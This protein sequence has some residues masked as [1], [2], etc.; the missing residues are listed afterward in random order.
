MFEIFAATTEDVGL[1]DIGVHAQRVEAMGYDGLFV[2][3]AVHDGLLLAARALA[4]TSRIR[5]AISVLVAFP[6]SPMNVALAAW[7]LQKMSRGRFEL[8]L[9]TQIRQNIEERYSARWLPPA[10]GMR[11]YVGALRAI[12]HSFRNPREPLH[13]VGEHYRFTRLQPFFNPG[14]IDAPDVPV[15]LGAVGPKMLALVGEV[16]DGMHTHPTNTSVRCLRET[17]LPTVAAGTL[18]R[19]PALAKPVICANGLVAT[20]IDAA[21]VAA[22]RERLR[23]TLAFVFSTPA[24]WR[25]LE[26]IG[27]RGVGERL[28]ALTRE[29]RWKEMPAALPDHVLDEFLVSGRYQDLPRV[30]ESRFGGLVDRIS[31]TVPANPEDDTAC[32]AAIAALRART[33]AHDDPKGARRQ[34]R[35][36]A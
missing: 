14:P 10:A 16:A 4:C 2:S 36:H 21:A 17:I 32:T 23:G 26:L 19:D 29:R 31:L 12:F 22:E 7:D 1:E 8:G 5:V 18:R 27:S 15:M 13:F 11:E 34:G 9:G 30:L 35:D 6:R 20:G 3:D 28:L 24:Y 25:S 33:Q